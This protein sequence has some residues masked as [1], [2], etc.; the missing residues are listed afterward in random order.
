M[1]S[2]PAN[3]M[4]VGVRTL[5][6]GPPPLPPPA[7]GILGGTFD[8]IHLAHLIVAEEARVQL[9]LQE[10]VLA[11]TGDPYLRPERPRTAAADRLA[12]V[13]IAIA[14]NPHFRASAV[15]IERAGPSYTVD[16]IADLAR[17]YNG[18]VRFAF[19]LGWDSL[20]E[21]H[22]WRTP[23]ALARV[24]QLVAVRRPGVTD[25]DWNVLEMAVPGARDRILALDAP[26]LDISATAIRQ[27]IAR[28]QSVR[29][30]TPDAVI[31]YIH[32]RGLYTA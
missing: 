20:A 3:E 16:T 6:G 27:R 25:P 1:T 14:D 22:R 18:G 7:V 15:D 8:P 23:D 19:L 10:V 31:A 21:L 12:M 24:C 17:E 28:G 4:D 2:A 26:L 30:R 5:A 13:R 9:G 11:P 29:Y 32:E